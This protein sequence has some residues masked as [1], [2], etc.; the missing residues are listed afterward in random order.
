[1]TYTA[2]TELDPYCPLLSLH[3]CHPFWCGVLATL[4]R[5]CVGTGG[6]SAAGPACGA[7]PSSALGVPPGDAAPLSKPT[8]SQGR[9]KALK[10]PSAT[11]DTDCMPCSSTSTRTS[12]LRSPHNIIRRSEEH[13]SEL[14]SLMRISYAVICLNKKTEQDQCELK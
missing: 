2:T 14:Q 1:M 5:G 4:M 13:T 7:V 12:L 9:L 8:Q 3:D 11:P 6:S 10:I